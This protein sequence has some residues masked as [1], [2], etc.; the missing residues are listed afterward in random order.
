MR[1]PFVVAALATLLCACP[2]PEGPVDGGGQLPQD[3]GAPAPDASTAED[4]GFDGGLAAED[5]GV[6][7]GVADAGPDGGAVDAGLDAGVVCTGVP[8]QP[9]PCSAADLA[10]QLGCIPGL[11]VGTVLA[12]AGAGFSRYELTYVQPIDHAH[13]D[14]G[15]FTQRA[16]LLHAAATAPVVLSTS[17]YGLSRARTELSLLFGTNQL[18]VE[19]RY[20]TPSIPA[21]PVDW[22]KLDIEQSAA[23]LHRLRGAL[24]HLYP[25]RW[26]STGASKG[27]MT[28]VYFRR[29]Y[30][31]DV[32]GTVAYVAPHT[33]QLQDP[34]SI[35]FLNAVGGAARQV[36]RDKLKAFQQGVL[37]RRA[38]LA[39]LLPYDYLLAGGRDLALE[40]AAIDVD[41]AFWQYTRPDNATAGCGA[42]PAPDAPAQTVLNYLNAIVGLDAYADPEFEY[43]APYYYQAAT[44]LGDPAGNE[45]AVAG[46]IQY[47]GTHTSAHYAPK[48]ATVAFSP[49]AMAD[50]QQW[51]STEGNRVMLI[52]GELDPWS[53]FPFHLGKAKDSALYTVPGGNHGSNLRSLVAADLAQA[54]QTLAGWFDV[55]LPPPFAPEVM[56]AQADGP[57]Y[58]DLPRPPR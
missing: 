33:P 23:D 21:P 39:P 11:T 7:G 36:C 34:R 54:K 4:A 41:F 12:D 25:K 44:Q 5:S 55:P 17:G 29:F 22:S 6:D 45:P 48:G 50:V 58:P 3:S 10:G 38:E 1:S 53:A 51:L 18:S 46:L 2:A 26:V 35:P 37:T 20:F 14:A 27:G 13:P 49:A 40:H 19:H 24:A 42:I 8:A 47:P 9:P 43:F 56:P 31:C 57:H 30:P 52:Y 28:M 16:S 15:T 32:D